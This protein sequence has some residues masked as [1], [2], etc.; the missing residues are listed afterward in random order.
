MYHKLYVYI[1]I[2]NKYRF[3]RWFIPVV[4][5]DHPSTRIW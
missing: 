3:L 2:I 5:Y 4:F 1:R